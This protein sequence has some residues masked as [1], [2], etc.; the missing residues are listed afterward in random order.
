MNK[1]KPWKEEGITQEEWFVQSLGLEYK[2]K[3]QMRNVYYFLRYPEDHFR[4]ALIQYQTNS[5]GEITSLEYYN[6]KSDILPLSIRN[7]YELENL[8]IRENQLKELPFWIGELKNLT[9]LNLARNKIKKLPDNIEELKQLEK[10]ILT[11]NY[12]SKFPKNLLELKNLNYIEFSFNY[13][14]RIPDEVF[15][16][17]NLKTLNIFN[18]NL[19]VLDDNIIL[20]NPKRA[21]VF[22]DK[23]NKKGGYEVGGNSTYK[24]IKK[25]ISKKTK[26]RYYNICKYRFLSEPV[27]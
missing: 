21:F 25:V 7:L 9:E 17:P 23:K 20:L 26:D 11:V 6:P 2:N 8:N 27:I 1:Y 14:D 13:V 18:C 19:P 4:N 12:F 10:I 15:D 22:K 5:K 3:K 16:L 24:H